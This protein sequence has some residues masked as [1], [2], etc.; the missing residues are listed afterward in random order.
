MASSMTLIKSNL[1]H[2]IFNQDNAINRSKEKF[3][4]DFSIK[5]F[6]SSR[7]F[8]YKIADKWILFAP[9]WPGDPI[10]VNAFIYNILNFFQNGAKVAK[11]INELEKDSSY[12]LDLAISAISFLEERGFIRVK[13]STLPYT[14]PLVFFDKEPRSLDV[15]LHIT[16]DCNLSCS[17]CF[18]KNKSN[19][20][21][22]ENT[23]K[24]ISSSLACTA[25]IHEIETIHVIFAGGEPT[26]EMSLIERFQNLLNNELTSTNI[27]INSTIFSNGT[28]INDRLL[29]FLKRTHTGITISIDGIGYTHNFS[30]SFKISKKGSW[31]IIEKNIKKLKNNDI[32]VSASAT[33]TKETSKNLIELLKW[34]N[35]ENIPINL[36]IARDLNIN[37][38]I[39]NIISKHQT[40]CNNMKEAFS[41]TFAELEDP[42]ININPNLILQI[43][44]LNFKNPTCISCGIGRSFLVF[45][46]DGNM[47]SCPFLIDEEGMVPSKDLMV[48][49][50]ECFKFDVMKRDYDSMNA[51][52]MNCLWFPVC[53]GGCS[54]MNQKLGGYPFSK[55]LMCQ[56]Y[57]YLIPRYIIFWGMKRIQQ[58]K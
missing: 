41:R 40:L 35:D 11:V 49:C 28:L 1:N 31:D 32:M 23:L 26:L 2:D 38:N 45:K 18:Q 29:S 39:G 46:T 48:S 10:I 24:N 30:R 8:E 34:V 25:K 42:S 17:Y 44:E 14:L 55:S 57:K 19:T 5:L 7:I 9:D 51:D 13:P 50:K 16:N 47:V 21:M 43:E 3:I 53:S 33:L 4:I 52:C 58:T 20:S 37:D 12:D 36:G 27:K 22:D 6:K 15:W 54:I 56:F